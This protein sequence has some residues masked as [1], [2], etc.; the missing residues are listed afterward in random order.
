MDDQVKIDGYR[1]ELAEI[2]QVYSL[3]S[4]IEQAVAMVRAGRLVVYIKPVQ[5]V[6]LPDNM[7]DEIHAFASRSLTHYMMPK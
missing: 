2:E 5:G 4:K 7:L 6:V 1:I 3:H